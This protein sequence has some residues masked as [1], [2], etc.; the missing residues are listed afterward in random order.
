MR[1]LFIIAS[2][3]FLV[4]L[5][6]AAPTIKDSLNVKT[7]LKCDSGTV[8]I[9]VVINEIQTALQDSATQAQL[10]L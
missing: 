8:T 2:L 5:A 10:I 3:F 9:P 1:K 4:Q 7:E 6:L